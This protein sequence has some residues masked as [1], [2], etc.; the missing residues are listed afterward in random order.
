MQARNAHAW[1]ELWFDGIGW[2]RFEPTPRV[3][4]GVVQPDY[5]RD[6]PDR[7]SPDAP[8]PSEAPEPTTPDAAAPLPGAGT[9][10][11]SGLLIVAGLLAVITLLAMTSLVIAWRRRRRTSC[12]EPRE[13][14][15]RTW[16]DLGESVT[17]LGWSW[18]SAA[19]PREAANALARQVRLGESERAALRRLVWWIEQVRYAPPSVDVVPPEP[20]ELR[21]DL[22]VLRKA[23]NHGATRS[24]RIR[25]RLAPASLLGG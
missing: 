10:G 15:E 20:S 7:E 14:I 9:S 3:G 25:S 2:V 16:R 24:R 4:A 13:R 21:A 6:R 19:T 23:A 1:P 17:D 5:S 11:P 22:A 8:V 18:S 12:P